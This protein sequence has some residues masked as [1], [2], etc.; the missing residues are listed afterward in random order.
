MVT[1]G[2]ALEGADV[3]WQEKSVME[4]RLEFVMLFDQEGTNRR[5]LCRRFGISPTV[6]YRLAK[7]YR[8][9]GEAGLADRSRRPHHSPDRTPAAVERLVVALRDKHPV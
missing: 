3:P 1:T 7:R 5:E 6:G 9:E 2:L 4:Q 8:E